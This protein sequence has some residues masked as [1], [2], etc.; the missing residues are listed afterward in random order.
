M[1]YDAFYW[2]F[3]R[4]GLFEADSYA[5]ARL[6]EKTEV[7]SFKCVTTDPP[8]PPSCN[9]CQTQ[10]PRKRFGLGDDGG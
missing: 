2:L 5:T 3:R 6:P 7:R 4:L 1:D 10:A 8:P 9:G